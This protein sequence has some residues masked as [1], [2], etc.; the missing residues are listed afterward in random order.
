MPVDALDPDRASVAGATGESEGSTPLRGASRGDS[1]P[2]GSRRSE[3]FR[4]AGPSPLLAIP[5]LTIFSLFALLPLAGI[6]MLSFM[7][8]DG[9]NTPSWAG[10]DNWQRV[11]ADS[12]THNS[13]RLTLLL[14]FL[15]WLVQ[16]PISILLGA[17]MAGHQRY[18][19][20][21]SVLYFLPLLFSAAAVGIAWQALLDPNFGMGRAFGLDWLNQDWLG[22]PNL[23]LATLV[24][25]ISWCFIPFHSL[26]YQGAV[27]QVPATMYEAARIDGANRAQ[28]FFHVTVPQ[29][30]NTIITSTTLMIVGSLT[31]FDLIFVMTGGGPGDATRVLPLD[32]YLRGFRSYDMGAASVVGVLLVVVGLLISWGLNRLGGSNRMDS[33]MEGA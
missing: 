5:A 4:G 21:L 7:S 22:S 19:S 23:A 1:R 18:R 29:I 33:Q 14:T 24:F 11:L 13:I 27:R 16:F 3:R 15:T 20:L 25:V 26:L 30:K 10:L 9:L 17:F 6:L 28:L 2:G 12:G 32:M 31:Y 8:W